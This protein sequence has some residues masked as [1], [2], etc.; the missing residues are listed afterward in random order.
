[1]NE[2]YSQS[3]KEYFISKNKNESKLNDSKINN[4]KI[5]KYD[6]SIFQEKMQNKSNSIFNFKKLKKRILTANK[7]VMT[8][9]TKISNKKNT[10]NSSSVETRKPKS[11]K[12]KNFNNKNSIREIFYCKPLI[13][14]CMKQSASLSNNNQMRKK[15]LLPF[16]NSF[17][18]VLDD[19]NKKTYF[20]KGSMDFIYPRITVKKLHEDKKNHELNKFKR[21]QSEKKKHKLEAEKYYILKNNKKNK[22]NRTLITTAHI[23]LAKTGENFFKNIF[24]KINHKNSKS[25]DDYYYDYYNK[26]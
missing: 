17:G 11:T 4:N 19:V 14:K 8:S 25:I 6:S 10:Y 21:E 18:V 7:S 9:S 2:L 3:C 12:L 22:K 26:I 23:R 1:M 15:N 24:E 20:L 13:I 16:K 5:N